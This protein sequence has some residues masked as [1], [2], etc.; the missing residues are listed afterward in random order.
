MRDTPLKSWFTLKA[1]RE[2]TVLVAWD[3]H[4]LR[5]PSEWMYCRLLIPQLSLQPSVGTS[6]SPAILAGSLLKPLLSPD[7]SCRGPRSWRVKKLGQEW[8]FLTVFIDVLTKWWN[9]FQVHRHGL[10]GKTE[11]E[12][13]DNR[14]QL[15]WIS[16]E[17]NKKLM[18]L[19]TT[20]QA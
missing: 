3:L 17:S 9:S 15:W 20:P 7:S 6:G 13:L 16:A 14:P 4:D 18:W 2:G 1:T 8:G 11:R 5:T 12:G 10:S 19:L